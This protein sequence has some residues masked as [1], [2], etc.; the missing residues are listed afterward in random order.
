MTNHDEVINQ[1]TPLLK[2]LPRLLE[3]IN[4]DPNATIEYGSCGSHE[5]YICWTS[6]SPTPNPT[7]GL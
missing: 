4:I 6:L 2:Q 5:V 7:E 1:D 3:I